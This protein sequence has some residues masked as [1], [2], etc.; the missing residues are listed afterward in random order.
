MGK[1]VPHD[2]LFKELLGT[3]LSEFLELFLPELAEQVEPGS[4]VLMGE[5]E[6][7]L[8]GE[9]KARADLVARARIRGA[10]KEAFFL[11]P[12]RGLASRRT[13]RCRLRR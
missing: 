2:R 1:R 4:L 6:L 8:S 11:I 5:K 12:A 13:S 3:F 7:L 9:T 10:E